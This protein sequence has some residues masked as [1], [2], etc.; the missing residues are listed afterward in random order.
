MTATTQYIVN[1]HRTQHPH[2]IYRAAEN[3]YAAGKARVI[4]VSNWTVGRLKELLQRAQV[5][6]AINQIEIHPYLPNDELVAYCK[7]HD[8]LPVGLSLLWRLWKFC[9]HSE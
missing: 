4:G 7:A 5:P 9:L 8:I 2:L 1:K 6:P 3:L